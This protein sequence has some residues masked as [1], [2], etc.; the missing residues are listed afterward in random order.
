M[1]KICTLLAILSL[2][3][4]FAFAKAIDS[5]ATNAL[6]LGILEH[7]KTASE[8]EEKILTPAVRAIFNKKE[9]KWITGDSTK[10]ITKWKVLFDG[11]LI[12]NIVS[13]DNITSNLTSSVALQ[14]ITSPKET[15]PIVGEQT[16][17]FATWADFKTY[18]PLIL[19]TGDHFTDPDQ[20]KRSKLSAKNEKLLK[21]EFRTKFND[22][23]NCKDSDDIKPKTWNYKDKDIK[24]LKVYSS[25]DK[26]IVTSLELGP[27]R[28]D[29]ISEDAYVSNWFL[30][31]PTGKISYLDSG[32]TLIDAG[33]YDGDGK[34]EVVFLVSRYNKGGYIM[35]Y[36]DFKQNVDFL[37]GYH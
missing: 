14:T 9:G 23:V 25:K 33:D 29:G 8:K 28:C 7:T 36:D 11:K 31:S 2:I 20:W 1:I 13:N 17:E 16:D 3:P 22:V 35:Y 5:T 10:G 19:T 27:Y 18:R 30:I 32:M 21:K 24:I 37:F 6:H 4:K 15:I 26:W 34:T 12:G